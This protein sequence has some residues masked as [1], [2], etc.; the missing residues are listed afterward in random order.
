M[1]RPLRLVFLGCALVACAPA[2]AIDLLRFYG[3]VGIGQTVVEQD[4]Y[5]VDEHAFGWK[6]FAGYRPFSFLGVEAEYTDLGNKGVDTYASTAHVSTGAH[7]VAAFAVI[8]LPLPYIDVYAKA[9]AANVKASTN[10]YATGSGGVPCQS[11]V[12]PAS[13]DNSKSSA[14]WGAGLGYKMEHWG[15]RLDYERFDGPQG[16]PSILALEGL[17]SF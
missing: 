7:A 15:I 14:A 6:V 3:G 13:D 11:C 9:G 10:A 16:N 2:F 5:Q 1:S 17:F 12:L 4:Y 8:Y